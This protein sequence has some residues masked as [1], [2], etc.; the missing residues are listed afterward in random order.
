MVF[1]KQTCKYKGF[2]NQKG[3][4]IVELVIVIAVIGILAAVLIPT[5]NSIINKANESKAR[6]EVTNITKELNLIHSNLDLDNLLVLYYEIT[7][8]SLADIGYRK[9]LIYMFEFINRE[10]NIKEY[11]AFNVDGEK[12]T[13]NGKLYYYLDIGKI[14]ENYLHISIFSK[15]KD[16]DTEIEKD[17]VK[18]Y[19]VTIDR[20]SDAIENMDFSRYEK[21]WRVG[22]VIPLEFDYHETKLLKIFANDVEVEIVELGSVNPVYYLTITDTDVIVRTE[23]CYIVSFTDEAKE[24]FSES[25]I[26]KVINK[27]YRKGEQVVLTGKSSVI[28]NLNINETIYIKANDEVVIEIYIDENG[29]TAYPLIILDVENTNITISAEKVKDTNV[30]CYGDLYPFVND[31]KANNVSNIKEIIEINGINY[32]NAYEYYDAT[33]MDMS[34]FNG[35]IYILDFIKHLKYARFEITDAFE[36]AD[37]VPYRKYVIVTETEVYELMYTERAIYYNNEYY[38]L[39]QSDRMDELDHYNTHKVFSKS[40]INDSSVYTVN[41][42]NNKANSESNST[43][44]SIEIIDTLDL[45][46]LIFTPNEN[47]VEYSSAFNITFTFNDFTYRILN[48][49]QF[50]N[51]NTNVVYDIVNNFSFESILDKVEPTYVTL[52]DKYDF[53][54]TIN[55]DDVNEIMYHMYNN[56]LINKCE[57]VKFNQDENKYIYLDY[58][59]N[60]LKTNRFEYVENPPLEEESISCYYSIIMNDGT[61]YQIASSRYIYISGDCYMTNIGIME[62]PSEL[63]QDGYTFAKDEY[64]NYEAYYETDTQ[65]LPEFEDVVIDVRA[66]IFQEINPTLTSEVHSSKFVYDDVELYFVSLDEYNTSIALKT[67]INEKE[68]Y[69]EILNSFNGGKYVDSREKYLVTYEFDIKNISSLKFKS[70]YYGSDYHITKQEVIKQSSNYISNMTYTIYDKEGN[71][72]L[73]NNDIYYGYNDY[74]IL[75]QDVI[76]KVTEK[77]SEYYEVIRCL[78]ENGLE[79]GNVVGE[80]PVPVKNIPSFLNN[81]ASYKAMK[82]LYTYKDVKEEFDYV[83]QTTHLSKDFFSEELFESNIVL[84]YASRTKSMYLQ[85]SNFSFS[86]YELYIS[87]NAQVQ[88]A[89]NREVTIVDFV[90][91]PKNDLMK[92]KLSTG[93]E[94]EIIE[95]IQNKYYVTP[96]RVIAYYELGDNIIIYPVYNNLNEIKKKVFVKDI[97][98]TKFV[99]DNDIL[100]YSKSK[101]IRTLKEASTE[102]IYGLNKSMEYI[103]TIH[104]S[105]NPNFIRVLEK[106]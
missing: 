95:A 6:Q 101:G 28:S 31:L 71:K 49:K 96:S 55:R 104:Y 48:N 30:I 10:L 35:Q 7:D 99:Y 52:S 39:S 75:N 97:L 89:N 87:T 66:I 85:Y 64:E 32:Q 38:V 72:L 94:S 79:Q 80:E 12:L 43:G 17:D 27:T 62:L 105:Y 65:I 74:Y 100:V 92:I 54:N 11:D 90:I 5:F 73:F 29:A 88:S 69:F 57:F 46:R 15:S 53:I 36:T 51:E 102:G 68:Y 77:V 34:T 63:K 42:T 106:L 70:V 67:I 82:L 59:L 76:I 14:S 19:S 13:I 41:V 37:E 44:S 21:E 3:F 1:N 56:E 23:F 4:T 8:D 26:D 22:S 33:Y 47:L 16:I 2:S 98:G 83:T 84:C 24:Y 60:Y 18:K 93:F 81:A 86:S 91:I 103:A 25:E 9:E 50:R 78:S 58:F 45:R 20:S 40:N 61:V